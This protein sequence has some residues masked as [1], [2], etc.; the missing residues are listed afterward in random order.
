MLRLIAAL[1]R[2]IVAGSSCQSLLTPVCVASNLRWES[3][4]CV[5]REA[6]VQGD[7]PLSLAARP[8][9][10]GA[11]P[12][13][14]ARH[15]AA[16]LLNVGRRAVVVPATLQFLRLTPRPKPHVIGPPGACNELINS[17]NGG[18]ETPPPDPRE[19]RPVPRTELLAEVF[20]TPGGDYQRP[21]D[22]SV[23]SIF[24]PWHRV[25]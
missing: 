10:P 8:R 15:H 6:L 23:P 13:D 16:L 5:A 20:R 21:V 22:A 14:G 3:T 4:E 2:R 18:A 24:S 12:R 11:F 19:R 25:I 7:Y 1:V 17:A 9:G